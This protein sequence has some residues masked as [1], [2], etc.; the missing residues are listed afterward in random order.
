MEY[1]YLVLSLFLLIALLGITSLLQ[2]TL[3]EWDDTI[4][5]WKETLDNNDALIQ[6]NRELIET[7]SLLIKELGVKSATGAPIVHHEVNKNREPDKL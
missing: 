1:L 5:S 4:S 7:N 3:N 6:L 2:E